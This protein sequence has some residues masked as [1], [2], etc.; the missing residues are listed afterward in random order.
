M[1]IKIL[2]LQGVNVLV[3]ETYQAFTK[4]G[5]ILMKTIIKNKIFEPIL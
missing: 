2:I 3:F 4:Q 5:F 1:D